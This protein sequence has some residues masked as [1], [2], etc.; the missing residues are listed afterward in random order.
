[1]SQGRSTKHGERL[2]F[3][4]NSLSLE[5]REVVCGCSVQCNEPEEVIVLRMAWRS[6]LCCRFDQKKEVNHA[7]KE[8]S[9]SE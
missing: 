9:A 7:T 2:K 4:H 1:V 3:I 5:W 8:K 6:G